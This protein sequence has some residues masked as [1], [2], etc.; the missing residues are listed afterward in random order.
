MRYF[1]DNGSAVNTSLHHFDM[2]CMG[3]NDMLKR[4]AECSIWQ[5][6][7]AGAAFPEHGPKALNARKAWKA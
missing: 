2:T 7:L 1:G 5:C 3:I 4:P 6:H